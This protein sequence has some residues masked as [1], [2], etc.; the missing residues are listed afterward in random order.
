MTIAALE[1]YDKEKRA[2]MLTSLALATSPT[3]VGSAG[4]PEAQAALL[5]DI[6]RQ[7]GI[8]PEDETP[9]ARS[10][11]DTFLASALSEALMG[12]DQ[13]KAALARAGMAG[14][15]S[16]TMYDIIV[17]PS[18]KNMFANLAVRK[19]DFETTVREADEAHVQ[20]LFPDPSID[21]GFSFFMRWISARGK[22]QPYWSV[23]GAH[24]RGAEL[25]AHTL[26]RI[27]LGDINISEADRPVDV[28]RAL[29]DRFG[30]EVTVA[31]QRGKFLLGIEGHL[32]ASQIQLTVHDHPIGDDTWV[33][34]ASIGHR[35]DGTA[36]ITI[37][38][39]INLVTYR[40]YLRSHG[41][42]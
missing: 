36:K 21:E 30:L 1:R 34:T 28:V 25:H 12:D 10:R 5:R 35:S 13:E 40:D 33:S 37:A 24:R 6:K 15:L 39:A 23:A 31:G 8:A 16:P 19:N 42:L 41:A 32:P 18:F 38:Y 14:R 7:I 26:W 9:K 27:Y 17:T 29:V 2:A 22:F 4:L 3:P 20:H 11:L